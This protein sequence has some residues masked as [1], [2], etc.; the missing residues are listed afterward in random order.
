MSLYLIEAQGEYGYSPAGDFTNGVALV[1]LLL[2]VVLP[3]VIV[4]SASLVVRRGH[5]APAKRR[6]PRNDRCPFCGMKQDPEATSTCPG[7]GAKLQKPWSG[8]A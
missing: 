2:F 6:R 7:C 4:A 8:V 3:I 1:G 5:D